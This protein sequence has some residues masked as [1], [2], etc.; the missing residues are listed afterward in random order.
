MF[1][2]VH[3]Y[4]TKFN[5]VCPHSKWMQLFPRQQCDSDS[6]ENFLEGH[7]LP[8]WSRWKETRSKL[9]PFFR[10]DFHANGSEYAYIPFS[11]WMWNMAVLQGLHVCRRLLRECHVFPHFANKKRNAI[12]THGPNNASYDDVELGVETLLIAPFLKKR[13]HIL[14]GFRSATL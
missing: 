1:M 3:S 8:T 12:R 6:G 14:H 2:C 13:Q 11:S 5:M 7:K 4:Y 9:Q 10:D